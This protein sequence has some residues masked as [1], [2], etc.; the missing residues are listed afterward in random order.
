MGSLVLHSIITLVLVALLSA[1]IN[2]GVSSWSVG[3]LGIMAIVATLV[4]T[5]LLWKSVKKLLVAAI[6]FRA[7]A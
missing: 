6:E 3:N 1:S 5:L 4:T 7:E 2:W